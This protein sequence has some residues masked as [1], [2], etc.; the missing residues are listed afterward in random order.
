MNVR[1]TLLLALTSCLL[2]GCVMDSKKSA[3]DDTKRMVYVGVDDMMYG[4]L[5]DVGENDSLFVLTDAGDSLW[6]RLADKNVLRGEPL[7]GSR[8]VFQVTGKT[9]LIANFALNLSMLMGEWVEPNPLA[10]GSYAGVQLMEGGTAASINS[11]TTE[12]EGWRL[13]DGKLLLVSSAIGLGL[14]SQEVDT[15][16]I[17]YLSTDSLYLE[18]TQSKFYFCKQQALKPRDGLQ[19]AVKFRD[20]SDLGE[21]YDLFNPEGSAPENVNTE[22]DGLMY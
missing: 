16:N 19:G 10:E 1:K 6:I 11:H 12:Y 8:M 18:G 20:E 4:V 13:L 2:T 14:D 17:T 3:G 9:T 21:R 5:E 15:L 7:V 22:E